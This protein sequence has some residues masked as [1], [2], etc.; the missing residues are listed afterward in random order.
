M[1]PLRLMSMIFPNPVFG[2][3]PASMNGGGLETNGT[4]VPDGGRMYQ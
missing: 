2:L 1:R 3:S 4:C